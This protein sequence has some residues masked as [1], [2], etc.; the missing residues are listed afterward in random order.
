[1]VRGLAALL[2]LALASAYF[3]LVAELPEVDGDAGRY[4]AGCC[5]AV[6]IG[7][8]A[9][10]PLPG[11]DDPL[12][13]IVLG[14]GAGLLAAALAA[15]DV[16][17]AANTVEALFAA[18]AG[19]LFA[20]GFAIPTAVVALPLLVAGIDAAAVLTGATE[21]LG[22]FDPVDVLTFDLPAWGG[23]RPSIASLSLLD[24]TFLAMFAAWALRYDLRPRIALPLMVVALAA[25]VAVAVA[26]DRA[27]PALPFVAAAFLVPSLTRIPR[28]VRGDG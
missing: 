26:L 12:A 9:L 17:A 28:L 24:A 19:L 25:A 14:A 15:Q 20:Y 13:L 21:P 6:A 16:G 8:A 1:V 23:E 11:R 7:I 10:A 27:I 22:D 4:L 3:L 5:G 18:S 2:G